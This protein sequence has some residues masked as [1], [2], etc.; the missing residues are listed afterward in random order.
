MLL[1]DPSRKATAIF[2]A[3]FFFLQIFLIPAGYGFQVCTQDSII[4]LVYSDYI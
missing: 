2:L 4:L 3:L 1:L